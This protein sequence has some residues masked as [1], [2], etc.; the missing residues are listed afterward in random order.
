VWHDVLVTTAIR[1]TLPLTD[2]AAC[3]SPIAGDVMTQ[4]D[5]ERLAGV[6]KALAEPARLRLVSIISAAAPEPVCVCELIQ[7]LA[8]TQPTVS[9]HLRV[10]TEAGILTRE[11]R[12]KWAFYGLVPGALA[13]VGAAIT[14]APATIG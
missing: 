4:D 3:C 9:H 11:Q 12:G 6:L 5:A 10:L 1:T 8:L 2:L 13:V 14:P 7:P